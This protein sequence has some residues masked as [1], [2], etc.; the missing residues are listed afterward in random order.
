[1]MPV[2]LWFS[3]R[4]GLLQGC[5]CQEI[6]SVEVE[7]VPTERIY[8]VGTVLRID[9]GTVVRAQFWRLIGSGKPRVSIFDHGMQYGLPS[10]V[11][12]IAILRESV[13][14]RRILSA[15]MSASTGDLLLTF[16]DGWEMEIF[17]FTAFEIWHVEFPDG[18]G[19]YSNYALRD[20][21]SGK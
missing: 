15:T 19:E 12:A 18:T 13:R 2:V 3:N 10:P 9:D 8:A 17:N 16:E 4:L 20:G 14:G 6:E 21:E 1:M 5:R 11:D 7:T